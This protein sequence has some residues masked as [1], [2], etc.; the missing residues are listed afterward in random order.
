MTTAHTATESE[1]FDIVKMAYEIEA[2]ISRKRRLTL[3]AG[4]VL[5]SA[6]LL[7]RNLLGTGLFL[8]GAHL[9]V[10]GATGRTPMEHA[11]TWLET[12]PLTLPKHSKKRKLQDRVD[13]DSYES[14]P[15]SDA[16]SHSPTRPTP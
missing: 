15:A 8:F 13:Q 11:K 4:A 16:P 10:K 1:T 5:T 2:R 7:K 12:G 14:F 6:G 9:L 3:F